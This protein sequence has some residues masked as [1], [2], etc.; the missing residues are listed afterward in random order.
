MVTFERTMRAYSKNPSSSV[1]KKEAQRPK[2]TSK[3]AFDAPP[4]I[5]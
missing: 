5:S 4:C 1:S 2:Q 3:E